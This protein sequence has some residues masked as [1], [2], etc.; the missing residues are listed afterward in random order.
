MSLQK[1][2]DQLANLEGV[3]IDTNALL[4]DGKN[5]KQTQSPRRRLG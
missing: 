5:A 3:T 2:M 4:A 1:E